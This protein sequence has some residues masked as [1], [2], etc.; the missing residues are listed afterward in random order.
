MCWLQG[1]QSLS[2][3]G[4]TGKTYL[5]LSQY[6]TFRCSSPENSHRDPLNLSSKQ[7]YTDSLLNKQS[8]MDLLLWNIQSCTGLLSLWSMQ[9]CT[10]SWQ[11]KQNYMDLSLLWNMQSYTDLSSLS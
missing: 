4:K 1:L 11:S 7:S 6:S 9:S 10:D 3:S 2:Q 5:L 8:Y